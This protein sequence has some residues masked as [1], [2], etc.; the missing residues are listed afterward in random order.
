[1]IQ[2]YGTAGSQA[3]RSALLFKARQRVNNLG[4]LR[5]PGQTDTMKEAEQQVI[6]QRLSSIGSKLKSGQK[7]SASELQF[8]Q[9]HSPELF[10]KAVKVAKEREQYEK[11]LKR[12]RSKEEVQRLHAQK[13]SMLL[14]EAKAVSRANIPQEKKLEKLEEI[15]MR[16]NNLVN[17]YQ[18]YVQ[19]ARYKRLPAKAEDKKDAKEDREA[20]K[21]KERR[22]ANDIKAMEDEAEQTQAE[23]EALPE[24]GQ[25]PTTHPDGIESGDRATPPA[26]KVGAPPSVSFSPQQQRALQAYKR[27]AKKI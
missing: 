15:S 7:L 21:A 14:C 2:F 24:D 6:S 5:Q 19:S 13:T 26:D 12:C 25:P 4:G 18:G 9:K 23:R 16:T 11:K 17:E 27:H 20:V 1:M 3:K 22:I 8:L 10:E